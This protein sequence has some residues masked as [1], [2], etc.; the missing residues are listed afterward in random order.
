MLALGA[1]ATAHASRTLEPRAIL[2]C[3]TII[4]REG[5]HYMNT[6]IWSAPACLRPLIECEMSGESPC[7]DAQRRCPGAASDIATAEGRLIDRVSQSCSAVPVDTLVT[8]LSFQDVMVG[9]PS[10]KHV[11]FATC[12]AAKL[13]AKAGQTLSAMMP[14]GCA[15]ID[16]GGVAGVLPPEI[17]AASD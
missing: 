2:R 17:C 8:S 14:A 12:L 16:A 1:I 9:C 5:I 13:R 10:T 15:Y 11:G 4:E 6:I 7:A 3:E